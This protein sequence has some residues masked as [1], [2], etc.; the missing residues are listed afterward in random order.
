ML[1]QETR[2]VLVL[3]G[4]S[5]NNVGIIQAQASNRVTENNK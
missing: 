5:Y 1:K 3:K 4:P 2:F